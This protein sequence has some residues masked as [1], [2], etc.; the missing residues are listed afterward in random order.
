MNKTVLSNLEEKAKKIRSV[1]ISMIVTAHAS[2]I[3]SSYSVVELIV[4]LYEHVLRID[5]KKP[6]DPDRDRF[7]LSKG[8]AVS[9]L[10][11]M[12]ADKGFFS[13]K[14]L[15]EY[16][17][18]GSKFL[19]GST[20]NGVLGV[21]ATTTS[22]GHG[23]PIGVGMAIAGKLQKRDYRVFV[24]ISDGECDEGST[25]ESFLIAAHHKLNNLVVIVD[26]NTWQSFGRVKDVLNLESLQAKL[27]AFNW[28]VQEVDGHDF[29]DLEK[30]FQSKSLA[31]DK[32]NFIIAHT[33]K[34]KGLS[35]LEDKNEWHYQTPREKEIA[36]AKEKGLL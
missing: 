21:E 14:F 6:N 12:L 26:Y 36:E 30:V 29:A 16:C 22:M 32:P 11:A 18:D 13:K 15:N 19:G 27:K 10:Y 1:V 4:Y 5:P 9:T 25:W 23:L 8:W 33:I 2:H 3:G 20:R 34:G 7:I 28:H 24:I 31:K 35:T 17:N